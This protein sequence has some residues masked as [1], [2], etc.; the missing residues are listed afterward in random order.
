MTRQCELLE[1]N[2]SSFYYKSHC[3]VDEKKQLILNAIDELYTRCPFY[4][5]RRIAEVLSRKGYEITPKQARRH[6]KTLGFEAIYPKRKGKYGRKNNITYPYLLD[7]IEIISP[8][9]VWATDITYIRMEKG[10]VYLTAIMDWFS[11]AILAWRI[12]NSLEADFCIDAL[13][14][15]L[16]NYGKPQIFNSDQGSQFTSEAFIKV[17]T[18]KEI[19]ISM[20]GRGRC[21]DNIMIERLWRTLKYEYFYINEFSDVRQLNMGTG[22]HVEFYNKERPHSALN[23]M[24]PMEVYNTGFK[25]N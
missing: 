23:Y 24:T 2:R 19:S 20:D 13:K 11:R 4:G 9:Q 16:I 21:F 8:N 6:M 7:K 17:L 15:A 14:E 22:I 3:Q 1:L 18:D 25:H 5:Y 10:F 12:S